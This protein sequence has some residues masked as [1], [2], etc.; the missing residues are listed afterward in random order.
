[1]PSSPAE[2]F[3]TRTA[4][5]PAARRVILRQLAAF[6]RPEPMQESAV[7]S[8]DAKEQ[9]RSCTDIVDL[10]GRS[11]ALRRQGRIYV[12]LCPWHD[13]T[14]PSLQVNPDRQTW[15]CWVCDIGGDVFSF[16]MKQ[17]GCDFREALTMLA[18]R[19]GIQLS[20]QP[21]RKAEPGSPDD[22]NTLYSCCEWASRQFHDC[23]LKSDAAKAARDYVQERAITPASVERFNVGFAPDDWSWLVDRAKST[24]YSPKV[25]EAAGLVGRGERGYYDRFKGR[26]IFP[27]RDTQGRTIAFGGRVLPGNIDPRAGKYVNCPE[28]RLY[29]KSDTLYALDVAK[30]HIAQSRQLIVV[31]GYTD[32]ILAH[33]HGIG[34]AIACCGTAVT[35]RHIRTLKRFADTIYLVLDGDDAGQRRTSEVLELFV[36]AQ[37]DLRIMTLPDELDPAEFVRERGG[38]AF[39]TLLSA[40]SDALEHKIST[41]TRGIDLVRDTHRANQAL[42]EILATIARGL[43]PGSIDSAG[44][45]AHQLL[46]RLARQFQVS[47]GDLRSR[48]AQLRRSAKPRVDAAPSSLPEPEYKLSALSSCECELFE[49]LDL[50]PELAPVALA[51]IAD[52]DL[53]SAPAMEILAAYRRR[54]EAGQALDFVA[55]LG[56]LENAS[57]K[58][59]LV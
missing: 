35:E 34:E 51:E 7:H 53:V 12:G 41:A 22:K 49:I 48:F 54:E 39:R 29:T 28:T 44:L 43:P 24:P 37:V 1:M 58:S 23:L 19:A 16:V 50:H 14:K 57:L 6:P 25:L 21:Q 36:A 33:Q 10:A 2:R 46:A 27:I 8:G 9:V 18:E 17:E 3:L 56:D 38:E 20:H 15:K 13:D 59:L 26:L 5:Q 32:V 31:E 52:E 11:I 47:D 30:N 55:V 42:E 40:A 4:I 45:R